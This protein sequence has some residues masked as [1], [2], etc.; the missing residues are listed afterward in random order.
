MGVM[1]A[2]NP[3]LIPAA[4]KAGI[5]HFDTAHG[6]QRGKNEEMLGEALKDY[7]RDSFVLATKVSAGDGWKKPDPEAGAALTKTFLERLDL[8]LKRLRLDY[9]DIL[10]VHGVDSAACMLH[11][12]VLAAVK[13]AKASGK[14]KHLGVSTHQNEPAVIQA[15]IDSGVYEVVLTSLNFKQDHLPK[16]REAIAKAAAAGI[17][18]VAMKTMAGGFLDKEKTKK[19]NARAALKFALQDENVTTAIPGMVNFDELAENAAINEDLAFTP[20]EKTDL[21]LAISETGLYCQACAQCVPDCPK[22]LP[23]PALMRAYMYAYGYRDLEQA[24]TLLTTELGLTANPCADCAT[25]T[26]TCAKGFPVAT[27]IADVTRLTSLPAEMLA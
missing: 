16:M 26:V 20:Q 8:S 5:T 22:G 6:Y 7:P 17:G 4:L 23:I 19:V 13:T 12:A 21:A 18:I 25:C 11:P 1:R 2:D 10:Y 24:H 9:V 27:K 3:A 15:A 14:A